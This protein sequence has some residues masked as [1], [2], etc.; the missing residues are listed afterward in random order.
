MSVW[1]STAQDA[2]HGYTSKQ[3]IQLDQFKCHHHQQRRHMYISHESPHSLE[4]DLYGLSSATGTASALSPGARGRGD[5]GMPGALC[6]GGACLISRV[7][8]PL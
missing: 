4:Y 8:L 3:G 5:V 2:A 7:P 1:K 6:C